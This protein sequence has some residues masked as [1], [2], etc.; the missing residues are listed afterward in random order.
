MASEG[1]VVLGYAKPSPAY[2][3]EDNRQQLR[4]YNKLNY[5]IISF[6][7]RNNGLREKGLRLK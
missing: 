3:Y 5:L 1:T 6:V 4:V 2:S 7:A